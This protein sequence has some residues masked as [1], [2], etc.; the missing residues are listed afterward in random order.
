METGVDSRLEC[1][2]ILAFFFSKARMK[3]HEHNIRLPFQGIIIE[4]IKPQNC[5][6]DT[7][8]KVSES[9]SFGSHRF[10]FRR[11]KH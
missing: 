10:Y 2:I 9:L 5:H 3:V 4:E 11:E 6:A 7:C 1:F 8:T